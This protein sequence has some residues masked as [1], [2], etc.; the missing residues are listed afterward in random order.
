MFHFGIPVRSRSFVTLCGY[1]STWLWHWSLF[2]GGVLEGILFN[3]KVD[4]TFLSI[5]IQ[6][7]LYEKILMTVW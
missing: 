1:M 4:I 5:R 7:L 3:G 6:L 2:I